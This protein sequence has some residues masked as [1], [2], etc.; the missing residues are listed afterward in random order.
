MSELETLAQP[1][2]CTRCHAE[3]RGSDNYCHACGKSLKPG[4]GF[5]FTHTGIIVMALVLG[6]L[7]LPFVWI[8]RVISPLAKIIY[9]VLLLVISFY[10]IYSLIHVFN[11]MQQSMQMMM[12]DLNGLE[13]GLNTLSSLGSF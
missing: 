4:H 8:S 3:V 1:I 5:L 7:V 9:T 10:F 11:S 13:N 6:P 2:L 12:G